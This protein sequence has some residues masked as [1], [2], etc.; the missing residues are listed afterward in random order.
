[1]VC[2]ANSVIHTGKLYRL[3]SE[4][5]SLMNVTGLAFLYQWSVVKSTLRPSCVMF[6]M[7]SGC[8]L[9]GVT[10]LDAV[11]GPPTTVPLAATC[12][13]KLTAKETFML[14]CAE[15][16]GSLNPNRYGCPDPMVAT[17]LAENTIGTKGTLVLVTAVV[18]P[19]L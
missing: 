2:G 3:Q 14:D 7:K 4:I 9:P 8:Q 11:A 15:L 6:P 1:M 12:G 18:L 10:G 13:H 5:T 17:C 19:Q 16:S